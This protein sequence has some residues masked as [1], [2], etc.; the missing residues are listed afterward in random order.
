MAQH[1]DRDS[2]GPRLSDLSYRYHRDRARSRVAAL[3][4]GDA[5]AARHADPGGRLQPRD[6]CRAGRQ[7]QPP[8]YA[9]V[10]PWRRARGA[11]RPDAGADPDRADR[12]GREHPDPHLRSDHHRWYRLDP[13]GFHC[14]DHG[15]V[16]RYPRP[17]LPAR[18][19]ATRHVVARGVAGGAGAVLDADLSVDDDRAGAAPGGPVPG[20]EQ[21]TGWFTLRN[22]VVAVLLSVLALVPVYVS[23]TGNTFLMTL[24]TR[25]VILAMAAT[26][27][28]L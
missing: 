18:P 4:P 13:G 1:L 23:I 9:R 2:A 6:G 28:N 14:R 7:H 15:R 22:I 17:R 24:F 25:I 12:D 16:D 8:L 11:R 20:I 10:R 26:S 27:L 19:H 21:M 5:H 3:S